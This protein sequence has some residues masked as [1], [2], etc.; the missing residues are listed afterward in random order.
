NYL[1]SESIYSFRQFMMQLKYIA[2]F[3]LSIYSFIDKMSKLK[4]VMSKLNLTKTD[5]TPMKERP[6]TGTLLPVMRN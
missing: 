3:A 2:S 4:T 5:G 6:S 1:I